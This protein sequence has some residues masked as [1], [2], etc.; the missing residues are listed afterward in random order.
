M[1]IVLSD[2]KQRA[3]MRTAG[4]ARAS[5]FTW[6]KTARITLEVYRRVLA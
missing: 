5:S 3:R 1:A 6:A 2:G 4:R